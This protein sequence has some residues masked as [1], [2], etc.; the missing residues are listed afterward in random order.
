MVP[1]SN[2]KIT[3]IQRGPVSVFCPSLSQAPI[4]MF[5]I[6]PFL[7][8]LQHFFFFY[9]ISKQIHIFVFILSSLNGCIC[10][11]VTVYHTDFII[12]I[13]QYII[14]IITYHYIE[15]EVLSRVYLYS[16]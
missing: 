13:Y 10:K 5:L 2:C 12:F 6:Y 4:R 7:A 3:F 1:K 15:I 16:S 9:T 14:D 11:Q 8:H